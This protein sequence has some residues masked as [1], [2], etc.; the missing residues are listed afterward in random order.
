MD[1]QAQQNKHST[2]ERHSTG[3]LVFLFGFSFCLSIW[4]EDKGKSR[5]TM[6]C[7]LHNGVTYTPTV[8]TDKSNDSLAAPKLVALAAGS[9]IVARNQRA[10]PRNWSNFP[11]VRY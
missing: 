1:L 8:F 9:S 6:E 7:E 5:F 2:T 4:P 3:A 10:Y 11:N